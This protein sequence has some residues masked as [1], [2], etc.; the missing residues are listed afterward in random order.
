LTV[1]AVVLTGIAFTFFISWLL[2]HT[3]LKGVPSS[4]VLELPP[5]RLPQVGSVIYRSMIDRTVFV[6]KRALFMA[7]PAGALIW[8]LAN[9]NIGG[10]N[11]ISHLALYL[12]PLGYAVGLDGFILLAFILGLPA[13][14]IVLPILLMSYLATGEM[15]SVAS[16]TELGQILKAN[17][18]TLLTAV[19]MM[20]FCLLHWPC[21]TTLLSVYK[22]S[23][24]FKWTGLAFLV[25][26]LTALG[27]CF[28]TATIFRLF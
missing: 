28:L 3:V 1:T 21:T 20:L 10:M 9:V 7:A 17:G 4:F 11:V 16:L 6:L 13:N 23:G 22:E 24:S 27:V 18:W 19:N 8:L 26:A 15:T 12:Q 2:S 14:E 25:P 5:Y